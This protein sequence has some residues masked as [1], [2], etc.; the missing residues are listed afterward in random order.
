MDSKEQ[1]DS[2]ES[3][4]EQPFLKYS[5]KKRRILQ[6]LL[7][8]SGLLG[9]IGCLHP[10]ENERLNFLLGLPGLLLGNMWCYADAAE[11]GRR[12]GRPTKLLLVFMFIVGL[13]VHLIQTRGI[14]AVKSFGWLLLFIAAMF[15][16]M[17][18]AVIATAYVGDVAGWWKAEDLLQRRPHHQ[19]ICWK[20]D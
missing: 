19:V 14:G 5:R 6:F 15:A 12:I 8:Y 17:L 16:C 4:E 20:A 10:E 7:A 13:P 9:V 3:V 18:A 11:R 2:L 1:L